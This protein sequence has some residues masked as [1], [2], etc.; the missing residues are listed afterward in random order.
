MTPYEELISHTRAVSL[1]AAT[2]ALLRWDQ[3]TMM[4]SGGIDYRSRQLAQL[5]G[6]I[7]ERMTSPRLGEL[8][9]ACEADRELTADPASDS[10]VNLRELRRAYDRE[11]LIPAALAKEKAQAHAVAQHA[12]IE[13]RQKSDFALFRPYL[14]RNVELARRTTE[15][16]GWPANGE[17]WDALA[18]DYERGMTA[19]D[20]EKLFVPLRESLRQL[21]GQLVSGGRRHPRP[22]A[23]VVLPRAT[24]QAFVR[25]VTERIGFDY[26]RGRLD[27]SAHPFCSPHDPG[28]VRLTTRFRDTRVDEALTAAMHEAGH[29]MYHQGL[30]VDHAGTPLGE[31]ASLGINESQSRMWENQIGRSEAFWRWCRGELSQFFGDAAS[32]FSVQDLYAGMNVVE[33]SLIRVEADEVTYNLHIMVRFE[34]ERALIARDLDAASL[35]REWNR[36]YKEYLNI[37]V[38][39]DAQG[40]MQDIHWSMGAFGY[41][42]TYTLG[43]LYAAQIFEKA[44]TDLS[45]LGTAIAGGDFHP[46][47]EWL[48]R[49]VH[50]HGSRYLPGEL[51]ARVTGK[52]LSSE[53]FLRYLS[54]KLLPLYG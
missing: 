15:C 27:V 18:D 54:D 13:A 42:P 34:L 6:L 3:E 50:A 11:T 38:P 49:N 20:V 32:K 25:A 4:P 17:P 39:N 43:N 40:C 21:L 16:Y 5:A 35:P 22:F 48:N 46:L 7:H 52:P 41:F 2:T 53:P 51:C 29:G 12:W 23:D 14:E 24:Q 28:D 26:S 1:L 10:A 47:K 37:D 19:A 33:P 9:A 31:P 45:D 36:L 44:A 8:I 30:P